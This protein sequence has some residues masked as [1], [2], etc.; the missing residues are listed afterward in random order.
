MAVSKALAKAIV[1][2]LGV[3]EAD[4][5]EDAAFAADLSAD[6]LDLVELVM[7]FEQVFDVTI[8]DT[9]AEQLKTVGD[10]QRWLEEH[11]PDALAKVDSE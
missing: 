7:T 5:T 11:A 10:V 8:D 3:D 4:I 9:E 1:E 6:S 2:Q